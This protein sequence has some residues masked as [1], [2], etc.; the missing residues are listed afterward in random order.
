MQSAIVEHQRLFEA[1]AITARTRALRAAAL[2]AMRFFADFDPRLVG[3]VLYGTPF[4]HSAVTLHL[5][6][7]EPERVTRMLLQHRIP[8]RLDAQSRRV[9]A[10]LSESYPVLATAMD[11]IDFELVVMPLVRL[12]HPP[13]SPLDGTPYR[14]LDAAALAALLASPG[15]GDLYPAVD[16]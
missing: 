7:D 3:P 5:F 11:E 12:Q 14:R 9:G 10:G 6:S 4:E 2:G 1:D 15:A 16:S 13:R 8:Y